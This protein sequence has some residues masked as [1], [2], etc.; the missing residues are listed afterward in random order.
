[1]IGY[2]VVFAFAADQH[3]TNFFADSARGCECCRPVR[4]ASFPAEYLSKDKLMKE[5]GHSS[6]PASGDG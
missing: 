4:I 3:L 1:M 2:I 5:G 6:S